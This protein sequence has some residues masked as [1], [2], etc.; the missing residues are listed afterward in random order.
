METLEAIMTRRS[1]RVYKKDPV[2]K[3]QLD[4]LLRAAIAAPSAGNRQPWAFIVVSDHRR[5]QGLAS[6]S[7]GLRSEPCAIIAIC[8]D[9][10]RAIKTEDGDADA[11]VWMDLG[12]AMENI[13]LAAHDQ[14]LGACAI[15]SYHEQGVREL[16]RLPSKIKLVLLVSI[17]MPIRV[18]SA[19]KKRPPEEV[20]FF[21]EYGT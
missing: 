15:G 17:G 5:L 10:T 14:G 7:P 16:L 20:I 13:L 1:V 12:G 6:L 9:E 4:I 18:P 2:S 8:L 11:M 19:P 3:E 21:E